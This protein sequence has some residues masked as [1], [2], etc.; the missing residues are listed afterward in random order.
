[1]I[2]VRCTGWRFC[3]CMRL[4]LHLIKLL[5][6]DWFAGGNLLAKGIFCRFDMFLLDFVKCKNTI[7][8]FIVWHFG[9]KRGIFALQFRKNAFVTFKKEGW[10]CGRTSPS[11]SEFPWIINMEIVCLIKAVFLTCF[12]Q[13]TVNYTSIYIFN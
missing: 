5:R 11:S 8:P 13:N 3:L 9:V 7:F 1:M 6:L 12:L 10:F 4:R 2:P